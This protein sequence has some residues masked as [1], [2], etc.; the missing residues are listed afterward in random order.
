MQTRRLVVDPNSPAPDALQAAAELLRAGRL[1]AF[2]TETV[3]GLGASAL[4][5][6][7]V[8]GIFQAKGRPARDPLIVHLSDPARVTEAAVRL[9]EIAWRLAEQFWPGPL[10]L[11]LPR[12]PRVPLA[13]TAGRET[14]AVRVPNH[15]VALALLR[16]ADVPV[17]APSANRF[18]RPSP[19]TAQHVLDDLDGRIALVL[20]GGPAT[21]GLESTILDLTQS[22]PTVLRPG[23][24]PLEA[25]QRVL[26]EVALRPHYLALE[27]PEAAPAPGAFIK[28]YSPRAEVHLF[29]GPRAEAL[30]AM[31]AEAEACARA[32][33]RVGVLVADEDAAAFAETGAEAA[34]LGT[35]TDAAEAGRRLFAAL[36]ALDQRGVEVI[37][38]RAPERE[39]LGLA[40][41]DR[42]YRA[43]EGRLTELNVRMD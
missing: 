42:L 17:A 28:H 9:P 11:V 30:P 32:G 5:E 34:R 29:S 20:D 8:A 3:Y 26:P 27:G 6:Q 40:L 25:L 35:E 18:S 7:A 24:T 37:L 1:V 33:R 13:V 14:V 39:G 10:T 31:R 41:W 4:D 12:H 2:P 19:T 38:A 43:A 36:R 16:A 22:P 15:P 23:G 21:I